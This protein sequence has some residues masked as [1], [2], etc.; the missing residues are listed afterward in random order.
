MTSR[1]SAEAGGTGVLIA[2]VAS[3]ATALLIFTWHG[4]LHAATAQP[5]DF[6]AFLVLTAALMLPAVDIYGK[7][8]ISV[9][10]VMCL[11]TGFTFGIGAGVVA[12]VFAAGVHAIRRRSKLRKALFNVAAFA[13]SAAAGA[14][15]SWES[16]E[17]ECGSTWKTAAPRAPPSGR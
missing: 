1:T 17:L 16:G 9:A 12:G 6:A 15:S 11:A 10:G 13:T 2:A 3:V 4:A 14:A 8:S 5:V 7:G